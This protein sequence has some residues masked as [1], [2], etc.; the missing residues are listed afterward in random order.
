MVMGEVLR[1]LAAI[2]SVILKR[3][4]N[5]QG[6][7]RWPECKEQQKKKEQESRLPLKMP[8]L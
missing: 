6:I 7:E 2:S 3:A 4:R 8:T 5:M 1:R